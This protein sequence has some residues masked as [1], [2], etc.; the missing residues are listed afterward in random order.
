MKRLIPVLFIISSTLLSCTAP[1]EATP[2]PTPIPVP[3]PTPLPVQIEGLEETTIRKISLSVEQNYPQIEEE[4]T[5]P[6]EETTSRILGSMGIA[7]CAQG[8]PCDASLYIDLVIKVIQE[9]YTG[10]EKCFAGAKAEGQMTL[11]IP[12]HEPVNLSIQGQEDPPFAIFSCAT[13]FSDAPLTKA[14]GQ[15]LLNG[16]YEIWSIPVLTAALQDQDGTISYAAIQIFEEL[17]PLAIESALP[18]LVD[19]L[20]NKCIDHGSNAAYIIR[21]LKP[22]D[23]EVVQALIQC[24]E[25][26]KA[27]PFPFIGTL[28]EI[29]P[30]AINAVPIL[31]GLFEEGEDYTNGEILEAL[32]VITGQD[33]G[34]DANQWLEWWEEQQ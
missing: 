30:T 31:V 32:Q 3:T 7:I 9:E 19:I 27:Y 5:Q 24:L 23:E 21:A 16:L 11:A 14:W 17:G 2:S 4:F 26:H 34:L 6:I 13:D 15:A 25:Q 29:G 1:V 10:G 12:A 22:Q 18:A 8:M 33:F 20:N 28:K